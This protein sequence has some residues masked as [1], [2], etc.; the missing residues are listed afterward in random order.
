MELSTILLLAGLL[1]LVLLGSRLGF[2]KIEMPAGAR[3]LFDTGKIF[4]LIGWIIGPQALNLLTG[5]M[6]DHLG[7]L[8]YVGLGWIDRKSTRLNSSYIP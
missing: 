4:I 3:I 7:S 2:G 8:I 6:I 1:A 5:S